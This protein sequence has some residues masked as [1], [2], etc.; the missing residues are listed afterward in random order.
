MIRDPS[1]RPTGS[2]LS[3]EADTPRL[4]D[5]SCYRVTMPTIATMSTARIAVND[6]FHHDG[7]HHHTQ[8]NVGRWERGT[9]GTGTT[10]SRGPGRNPYIYVQTR[11]TLFGVS[12]HDRPISRRRPDKT[13]GSLGRT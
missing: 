5:H 11:D 13:N 6:C 3:A 12:A 4:P 2:S 9:G 1:Y 8:T 7:H 10:P